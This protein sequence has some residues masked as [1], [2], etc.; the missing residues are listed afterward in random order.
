L[1]RKMK[2]Q[3][4]GVLDTL[5]IEKANGNIDYR[6]HKR[7]RSKVLNVGNDQIRNMEAELDSR[8]NI[9]ALNYRIEFRQPI[10]GG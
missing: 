5:D 6:T 8:Y 1:K 4:R 3:M 7:I 2:I 9:E 10:E